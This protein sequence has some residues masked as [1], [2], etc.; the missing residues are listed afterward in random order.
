MRAWDAYAEAGLPPGAVTMHALEYDIE[1]AESARFG[2]QF[3]IQTWL[4]P[5]P[6]AGQEFTRL[7][8]I[9]RG[10]VLLV[11]ARWRWHCQHSS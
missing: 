5:I 3:E 2:E 4:D 8:Q 10:D 11:R 7:Q 9:R 1:Y 6:Q